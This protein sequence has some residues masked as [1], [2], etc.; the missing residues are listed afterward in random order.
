[1]CEI[2]QGANFVSQIQRSHLGRLGD[3]QNRWLD[4]MLAAEQVSDGGEAAWCHLA[5]DSFNFEQFRSD[6]SLRGTGFVVGDVRDATTHDGF[7]RTK[8]AAQREDVCTC[9]SVGELGDDV[10]V[11]EPAEGFLRPF[12]PRIIA[13]GERVTGIRLEQG[14]EDLRSSPSCIVTGEPAFRS[15]RAKGHASVWTSIH[16]NDSQ[17]TYLFVMTKQ[18]NDTSAG[19]CMWCRQPMPPGASSGRP[20]KFCSQAC[21]Q[22]DWVA[23]QRAEELKLSEDELV[24][25]RAELDR[26][27]DQIFVLKCAI[28]DVEGDLDPQGDPTTRDFKAALRWILDAARPLVSADNDSYVKFGKPKK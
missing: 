12:R 9:A 6:D 1:M 14:S 3:R 23:R 27:R 11:E 28:D 20:R 10:A 4:V 18:N 16:H 21:R 13:I 19:K 2:A 25:Q 22:W 26:L 8:Q 15:N 7:R 5:V 24:I 17:V